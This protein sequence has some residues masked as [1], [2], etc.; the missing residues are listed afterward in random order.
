[1][2]A[3]VSSASL[4]LLATGIDSVFDVGSNFLLYYINHKSSRM[5]VNKWPVG[6]ARLETIGNVVY[7][8]SF[9][10]ARLWTSSILHLQV[11]CA[12]SMFSEHC[13]VLELSHSMGS[14]NFV[15]IVESARDLLTHKNKD[16]NDFHIPSVVAVGVA[17]GMPTNLPHLLC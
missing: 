16:L 10:L 5:D 7:G 6:G 17:L 3:A 9:W 15:V 14:V 1:M 8:T 2:Y 12:S 13:I 11:F 4:S